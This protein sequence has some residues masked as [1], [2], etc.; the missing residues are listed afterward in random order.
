MW[1]NAKGHK[2][3]V[4]Y[5]F[6]TEQGIDFLTKAEADRLAGVDGDYHTR[7]LYEAIERK[8]Y[9]SWTSECRSCRSTR[10]RPTASTRS[11]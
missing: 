6:K 9:P 1:V 5:H 4:K 7:D 3:W 2:F 10:P 11:T 8:D